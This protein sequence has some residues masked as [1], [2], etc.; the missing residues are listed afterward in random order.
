[1]QT[2]TY[3]IRNFGFLSTF[4][5]VAQLV[6]GK[7]LLR[8]PP[9]LPSYFSSRQFLVPTGD[10]ESQTITRRAE[11]VLF[12]NWDNGLTFARSREKR[13][14]GQDE[15]CRVRCNGERFGAAHGWRGAFQDQANHGSDTICHGTPPCRTVPCCSGAPGSMKYRTRLVRRRRRLRDRQFGIR[16]RRDC[17]C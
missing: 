11:L 1:M 16:Q 5:N 4:Q 6:E 2:S 13:E 3:F 17:G 15:E 14:Q 7:K 8:R 12:Q 9:L 10:R